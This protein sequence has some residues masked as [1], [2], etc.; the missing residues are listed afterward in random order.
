MLYDKLKEYAKSGAYPMHMPGHKRNTGF[1][2][3]GFPYDID[4]TEI[5]D[6]DNL[7][8]PCGCLLKIADFAARLYGSDKSF[9]LVN[10]ST[11][12][13]LAAIGAHTVRGDKILMARNCHLSVYNAV[14]L[15][16]LSPIYIQ[17][18]TDEKTGFAASIAPSAVKSALDSDPDI[19]LVVLTSP[20]FEGVVSDISAISDAVHEKNIPL[21]VD[22]AHGAHLGFSAKFPNSRVKAG[23]DIVVISL[24]KTL[25]AL[26]Q[27]A[28]LHICGTRA[29]TDETERLLKTLQTTSPSY[30]LMASI[31]HCLR[32]VAS[33][34]AHLFGEYEKK[35]E[36]FTER[37][38]ALKNLSVFTFPS[39]AGPQFYAHDPG[40]IVILTNNVMSGT[41][42]SEV[43]RAEYNIELEMA[44][45]SYAV[46]MTSICDSVEGFVRLAE[47]LIEI[48]RSSGI[49][50]AAPKNRTVPPLPGQAVVPCDA[51]RFQGRPVNLANAVG[52]MSLE[53][54]WAYPPGIPIITPGE[55]FDEN[56]LSYITFL[57]E[58]GITPISTKG[59]FPM[60][61]M[62]KN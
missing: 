12:G 51:L 49:S 54:I 29:N 31:D 44:C 59:N 60:I 46:A 15:F 27:C 26:T 53:Y 24:H 39:S 62:C 13:L 23:A 22:A 52:L 4:I 37:V 9:L 36:L 38:S 18:K 11:V 14:S 47:A 33:E 40:K 58:S 41:E 17:P 1:L 56:T 3:P 25:P 35:L 57:L 5:H 55:I 50:N 6:F 19:K 30:V 61:L 8:A 16:G 2:P 42:L 28:L 34:G 7:H 45:P 21:L 32:L 10:G 20:T 48:D 43:L